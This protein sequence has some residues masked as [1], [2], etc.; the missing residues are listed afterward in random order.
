MI[1]RHGGEI[2]K[3]TQEFEGHIP[4]PYGC[5]SLVAIILSGLSTLIFLCLHA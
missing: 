5:L 4:T 2:V 3:T 1:G